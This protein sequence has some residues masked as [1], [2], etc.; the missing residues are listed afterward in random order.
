MRNAGRGPSVA[1]RAK[2]HALP[3]TTHPATAR[4]SGGDYPFDAPATAISTSVAWVTPVAP[5]EA[6]G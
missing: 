3:S 1:E 2:A 6:Y 5:R 4:R